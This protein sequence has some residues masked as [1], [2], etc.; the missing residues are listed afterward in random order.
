MPHGTV[1]TYMTV[2]TYVNKWLQKG[3]HDQ[4]GGRCFTFRELTVRGGEGIDI[5]L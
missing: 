1:M 5:V 2:V 3:K 4:S